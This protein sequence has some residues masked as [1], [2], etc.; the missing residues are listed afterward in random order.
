MLR[1]Y[2]ERIRLPE[3]WTGAIANMLNRAPVD[4]EANV[5]LLGDFVKDPPPQEFASGLATLIERGVSIMC[6]YTGAELPGTVLVPPRG[7]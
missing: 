1:Y 7:Q 5:G 6:L 2:L 4:G 3:A